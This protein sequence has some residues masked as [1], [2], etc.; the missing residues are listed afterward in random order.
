M[1]LTEEQKQRILNVS[2]ED[3][4]LSVRAYNILKRSNIHTIGDLCALTEEEV[5]NLP[6][7]GMVKI[8]PKSVI[9]I[10][11]KLQRYGMYLKGS[12]YNIPFRK[13][14]GKLAIV[15]DS[16]S[17]ESYT[18][19]D[20]KECEKIEGANSLLC[21]AYVDS[22][23]GI[24]YEVLAATYYLNGDY[25]LVGEREKLGMK[26]RAETFVYNRVYPIENQALYHKYA[27]RIK[28][29][30]EHYDQNEEQKKLREIDILDKFRHP[31][32]PNDVVVTLFRKEYDKC[33]GV[34]VRLNGHLSKTVN[35][36]EVY[37]GELISEPWKDYGIHAG[38]TIYFLLHKVDN[39]EVL[40]YS[41]G[42]N[43]ILKEFDEDIIDK[44]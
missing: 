1:R 14:L 9:D 2:I 25:Y 30:D 17:L 8:G 6:N 29:I 10:T 35:G 41:Y 20:V 24:T 5:I 4:D 37:K 40:L 13:V 28:G 16:S 44:E 43:Q 23:M 22:Q 19:S 12:G 21:Y 3:L 34:W 31:A 15:I 27:E 39:G 38:Q 11:D 18:Q 7:R 42:Y 36:E 26:I 33:E 32:F